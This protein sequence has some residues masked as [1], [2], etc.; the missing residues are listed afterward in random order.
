M[1]RL[2]STALSS[3]SLCQRLS[4]FM[5]LVSHRCFARLSHRSAVI[6]FATGLILFT[7]VARVSRWSAQTTG[8]RILSGSLANTSFIGLPM[9]ETFYGASFLGLGI[10]IDQLG[11]YM[12]LSTVGI[13]VALMYSTSWTE[14]VAAAS[15]VLKVLKFTPF[16]ALLLALVL[17]PLDVPEGVEQLLDRLGVTLAPLALVLVG[18]QL[19]LCDLAGRIPASL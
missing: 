5:F 4:C 8:G 18:Y 3:T 6:F 9:I 1:R 15:V 11:T 17:R 16:Q 2:R 12:V 13:V 19:R 14:T 10:L 7:T